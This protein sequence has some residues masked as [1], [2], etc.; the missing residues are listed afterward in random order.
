MAVIYS[1]YVAE[2]SATLPNPA[3]KTSL[4]CTVCAGLGD[5]TSQVDEDYYDTPLLCDC[6][7][8]VAPIAFHG[9]QQACRFVVRP[10]SS[11]GNDCEQITHLL[12]T[13]TGFHSGDRG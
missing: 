11:P 6:Q 8:H 1:T 3:K 2:F 4:F 13:L 7:L 9:G 12:F 10:S 5:V